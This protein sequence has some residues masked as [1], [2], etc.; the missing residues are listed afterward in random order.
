MLFLTPAEGLKPS[1]WYTAAT[2]VLMVSWWITEPVPI[3]VT[4]L[5]PLIVLPVLGVDKID[6][7][8]APYASPP[9]YLFLGGFLLALA[10]EKW[11]LHKRIG[12]YIIHWIGTK[13]RRIIAGFMYSSAFLSMWVSNTATAIMMLPMGL[14]IIE[15]IQQQLANEEKSNI[16]NFAICLLLSIAYGANIGGIGTIIG[17]PP[18]ALM[19]SYFAN[20]GIDISFARWMM[21][22]TPLVVISLPLCY[23]L[24]TRFIFPTLTGNSGRKGNHR[25]GIFEIRKN[26]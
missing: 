17:T 24:L 25:K 19:V 15:L 4:A 5:I 18:N 1:A 2:G 8:A 16:R 21:V 20:R 23:Q 26:F 14:S 22:G 11:N 10:M 9:I 3:A 12:L 13:P 7:I 6:K